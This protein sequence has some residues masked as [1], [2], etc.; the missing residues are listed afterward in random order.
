MVIACVTLAAL[1]WLMLPVGVPQ[2][3]KHPAVGRP[4]PGFDLVQL[5]PETQPGEDV[6]PA[7]LVGL[8]D[9]GRV[10]LLHFWGTWCPPCKLEYPELI[11][12]ASGFGAE[13]RFRFV[14]VSCGGGGA[15]DYRSLRSQT[16]R[17]YRTIEAGQ[18][19]T[20]ADLAGVTRSEVST[21]LGDSMVYP[22]TILIGSD[23]RIAGVW[24]GYSPSGVAEMRSL[25][26]ELLGQ[27]PT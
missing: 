17:Y 3:A 20:F 2:P 25:I 22:T 27:T 26:V 15:E 9:A 10:T 12:M 7:T 14:T 24:L 21:V 13:P 4:S 1:F 19:E 5:I 23:G 8:P 18:L 16:E 6:E 11:E